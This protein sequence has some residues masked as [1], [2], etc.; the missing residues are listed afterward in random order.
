[1]EAHT[2]YRTDK[3]LPLIDEE[4]TVT[5]IETD[6]LKEDRDNE[7]RNEQ[8]KVD[9]EADD[10]D[11][12]DD[13]DQLL[14][15]SPL[16]QQAEEDG[17]E[18]T[19]PI[20]HMLPRRERKELA[21]KHGYSI[22]EFEEYMSLQRAERD[23]SE[24][25]VVLSSATTTTKQI[26]SS[27]VFGQ[28]QISEPYSNHLI[29]PSTNTTEAGTTTSTTQR[30]EEPGDEQDKKN[31]NTMSRMASS[32]STSTANDDYNTLEEAE[33]K[34][35][36]NQRLLLQA[37]DAT[38]LSREELIALGGYILLLPEELTQQLFDWLPVDM[39]GT[40]ALVSPHWKHLTLTEPVYQR[41]C[42]RL[43]LN[44]SKK[45]QLQVHKF[46]HCYRNMLLHR[47]RVRAAGGCYV[48]KY[49]H[50]KRIQRDMWT[51]VG[52]QKKERNYANNN[53]A[54]NISFCISVFENVLRL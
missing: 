4:T 33:E 5:L 38:T 54:T 47:P 48:L 37:Q 31:K 2:L 21:Q 19:W 45:R 16:W 41:L 11:D 23:S 29:Y 18:L 51:E 15:S 39:Y 13:D 8:Q 34:E 36:Q 14:N 30:K 52:E 24:A 28:S 50:V 12:D 32:V 17:W 3:V 9:D 7:D 40:L 53:D 27:L 20:W 10:E 44:Q 42:E 22:G 1:M 49:S 6:R 26:Q 46:G 25:T 43:Y 35:R